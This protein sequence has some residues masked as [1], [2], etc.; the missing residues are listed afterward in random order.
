LVVNEKVARQ[1][2]LQLRPELLAR[3]DEVIE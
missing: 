1:L 2:G 3:A